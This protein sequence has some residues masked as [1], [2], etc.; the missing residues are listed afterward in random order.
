[1]WY[2]AD[3]IPFLR[4]D[5]KDAAAITQVRAATLASLVQA[6]YTPDSAAKF[7][8]TPDDFRVL[9]H[10]GL[11]SV[12]LQAPGAEQASNSEVTE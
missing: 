9:E 3:D 10:T 2:D 8:M 12:Q 5:E 7:L 1:L 4:E 11:F 6:G